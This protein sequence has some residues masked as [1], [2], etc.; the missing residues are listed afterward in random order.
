[1]PRT[2]RTHPITNREKIERN[3]GKGK[4]KRVEKVAKVVAA[5]AAAR[6]AVAGAR[7]AVTARYAIRLSDIVVAGGIA[8]RGS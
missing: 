7:A 3:Q 6:A 5:V 8:Q 1:M 4:G 2:A